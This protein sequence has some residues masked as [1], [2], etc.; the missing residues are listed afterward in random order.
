MGTIPV[1]VP[2]VVFKLYK[3]L[4]SLQKV[5]DALKDQGVT[6]PRTGTAFSRMA[7]SNALH[8]APGYPEWEAKQATKAPAK[9]VKP[10]AKTATKKPIS[11]P[12]PKAQPTVKAP[13]KSKGK[14]GR[15]S[16]TL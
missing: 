11:Q 14:T 13:A 2:K 5:T 4:G 7:V 12:A 9:S 10:V 16:F 1:L 6:S 15:G 3:E 8:A